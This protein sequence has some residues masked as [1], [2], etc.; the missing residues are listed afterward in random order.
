MGRNT[1]DRFLKRIMDDANLDSAKKSNHS[2]RATA[3]SRM[4]QSNVPEK[5]IMERSGHLSRECLTS[6]EC[7][8]PAQQKALC[9]TLLSV[10]VPAA[11]A[12]SPVGVVPLPELLPKMVNSSFGVDSTTSHSVNHNV[13]PSTTCVKQEDG[14]G[15]EEPSD[16]MK[17]LQFNHMTSYT[18]NINFKV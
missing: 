16:L 3:I 14:S 9:S 17:K 1:L 10:H 6:Y 8:T 4:Y 11:N 12:I 15:A 18:I 2:L 7:T 13:R 5:L